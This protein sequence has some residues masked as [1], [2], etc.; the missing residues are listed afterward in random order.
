LCKW[1]SN[2]AELLPKS[3]DSSEI[4]KFITLDLQADTKT[5][6]LLW[7]C[8]TDKLKYNISDFSTNPVTKRGILSIIAQIYDL[9]GL[10][11]PIVVRAK[12]IL[13]NLWSLNL[14]WD[15]QVP[16]SIENLWSQFLTD[17]RHLPN[18]QI[19]RKVIISSP[20][21]VIELHGFCDASIQ[22]YGACVYIRSIDQHN[23]INV[24]LLCAKSRV[25][26]LKPISLPRLELCGALLLTRLVARISKTLNLN[27]QK[28]YYWTDSS[29]VLAWISANANSWQTFVANRISEIQDTTT[30]ADW[31]HVRS[32]DNPADIVSRGMSPKELMNS[33]L[34]WHGPAWL[35]TP[36]ENWPKSYPDQ[37]QSVPEKRKITLVATTATPEFETLTKFSSFSK[38][39]K[40]HTQLSPQNKQGF[41]FFNLRRIKQSQSCN[42]ENNST[43]TF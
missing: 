23:N 28:Q 40:I 11:S 42:S 15:D 19:P 34:W 5:L 3:T 6:G 39:F 7:N 22:A 10:I 26:P 30:R 13:Q 36:S 1:A 33:D 2:C 12:I 9:I 4:S 17:L 20:A 18:L 16:P 32:K 21:V 41:R 38:L 24:H 27:L 14:D 31:N 25:A 35:R 43:P 37:T 8:A 29:I